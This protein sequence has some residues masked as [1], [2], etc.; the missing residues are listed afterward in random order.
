MAQQVDRQVRVM[1][2]QRPDSE[3]EK[4]RIFDASTVYE[5]G[6]TAEGTGLGLLSL[7]AW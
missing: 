4:V 3:E 1:E 5:S 7:R 6:E 2:R